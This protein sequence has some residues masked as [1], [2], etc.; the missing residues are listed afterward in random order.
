MID[1][2]RYMDTALPDCGFQAAINAAAEAGGAVVQLPAGRFELDR[3]LF[4]RT[5]V[6]LRGRGPETVLTIAGQETRRDLSG[7]VPVGSNEAIVYGDLDGLAPGMVIFL[8][9]GDDSAYHG[10]RV[11]QYKVKQING[12]MIVLAKPNEHEIHA[13]DK[14]WVSWGLHTYLTCPAVKGEKAITV[15]HPE[16]FEVGHAVQVSGKGDSWGHHFNVITGIDGN[17]L[18]LERPLTIDAEDSLVQ[19][20][21]AMIT[22]DGENNIAVEDL[23][24]EGWRSPQMP[25]WVC[26]DFVFSAI[27][28]VRCDEIT[29]RNVEI[30]RWHSDGISIQKGVNCLVDE[31]SVIGCRGRGFH[32][33]SGFDG[34]EWTN[35]KA[36]GNELDGFYYC[37]NCT[38]INVRDSLL[39][40]NRGHGIGG[41]GDP[42]DRRATV[43]GNV[44]EGNGKSGIQINGGGTDSGTVIRGN[45]IRDNSRSQPGKWAGISI[46]PTGEPAGGY[47]IEDN[48]IAST[49][50]EPTQLVG[51]EERNGDPIRAEVWTGGKR[52][53]DRIADGNVI[54]GNRFSGHIRADVIATGAD[55]SVSEGGD[56]K[57]IRKKGPRLNLNSGS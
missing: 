57:I 7:D 49:L 9:P 14:P 35:L 2:T 18:E 53:V 48:T 26:L 24:I 5:G 27:H 13:E 55:T 46:Y 51:I 38:N 22:A 47:L 19:H 4:L 17:K 28:T 37:W 44:I 21:F 54:R 25:R 6:T 15:A 33:G 43:S 50:T 34:G 8:W 23:V 52:V 32:P 12:S 1:A 56:A 40:D 39:K 16:I 20:G 45:V 36:V 30:R 29:V 11:G 10:G 31:C 41:L 3:Y 42:G